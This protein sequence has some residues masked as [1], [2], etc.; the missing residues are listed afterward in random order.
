MPIYLDGGRAP[1]DGLDTFPVR[2][3]R[4]SRST[5]GRRRPHP[6]SA[7]PAR[8]AARSSS[9]RGWGRRLRLFGEPDAGPADLLSPPSQWKRICRVRYAAVRFVHPEAGQTEASRLTRRKSNMA[10]RRSGHQRV[11]PGPRRRGGRGRRASPS[12]VAPARESAPVGPG[13]RA[14]RSPPPGRLWRECD[15]PEC[16]SGAT[17]RKPAV[18]RR[19]A[20]RLPRWTTPT[21]RGAG[22]AATLRWGS[23][24]CSG[25]GHCRVWRAIGHISRGCI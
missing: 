17:W 21:R 2:T 16:R 23:T 13:D 9:G 12:D 6:A 14:G 19:R 15:P 22:R 20:G 3:S 7:A 18:R 10:S 4:R 8:C 24:R 25:S 5:G 1:F 11:A